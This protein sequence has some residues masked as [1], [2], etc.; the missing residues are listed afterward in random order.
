MAA[1]V[2]AVGHAAAEQLRGEGDEA[3][4]QDRE[5]ALMPPRPC[6]CL[7]ITL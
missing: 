4:R 6:H 2:E 7:M 3:K 5:K 1:E